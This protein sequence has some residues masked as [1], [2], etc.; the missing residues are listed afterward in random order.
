MS[1]STTPTPASATLPLAVIEQLRTA[2]AELGID[3][4][5]AT[6]FA[7][8]INITMPIRALAYEIGRLIRLRDI[9]I[10]AK[11][12]GTVSLEGEW[13][14]MTPKRFAGW[15][16]EFCVFNTGATRR[17]RDSLTPEEAAQ[18]LELDI[19]IECIR[20]LESINT[21]RLPVRRGGDWKIELLPSGYDT[22]SRIYTVDLVQYPLDWTLDAARDFLDL[23]G[24]DYP[25][26][27]PNE[28]VGPLRR[29]RSW[30]VQVAVMIG[31]FCRSFF[32]QGSPKPMVAIIGNQAG[33]GKSTLV[34]MTLMPVFGH[35]S[36]GKM[37]KDDEA[38]DKELETAARVFAPYLF[39]D[40]IGGGIF[41]TPL[42]R[43]ITASSHAGRC[44]GGN[45]EMF[46]VPN[47]TQVFV[48]GNDIKVSG[49]LMRRALC[50]ELHLATE[51]RGR[52]Y[53]RPITP[54]YLARPEIRAQF[55]AAFWAL[56]RQAISMRESDPEGPLPMGL[57]SF[58]DYTSTI[59]F[60]AQVAGYSDPLFPPD[61]SGAGNEEETEMS[62][63]LINLATRSA[64][65]TSFTRLEMVE[66]ART[67][68]VLESLVG[69]PGDKDLDQTQMKRWGRQLQRWRGRELTDAKGRRFQFS[70]RR[71]TKGATYPL[72]F[73]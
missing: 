10:R 6:N 70:R 48:T 60:I 3:L 50:I 21:M 66:A 28:E 18:I 49:D 58:E 20:P 71:M 69:L 9:F 73:I 8:T 16:E 23:H 43:F 36:A 22:E 44:M 54:L 56:V 26:A 72:T 63:L 34:A 13:K 39:L 15:L 53:T 5:G 17:I 33:T 52:T 47:V 27:F 38:M 30:A 41:S 12:I 46:R 55:L 68:G 65:N 14:R 19:F 42:N 32:P 35:A 7:P 45:S 4:P 29:N 40:D 2:A 62:D 25:W 37:C 11:E 1:A 61:L 64:A 59:S 51:V 67:L 24:K 31:T 57:E